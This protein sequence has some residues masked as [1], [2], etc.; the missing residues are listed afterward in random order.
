MISY[1]NGIIELCSPN[2][3]SYVNS[4]YKTS[5]ITTYLGN[6]ADFT[7][8]RCVRETVGV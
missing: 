1:I 4:N 6:R 5:K 3:T 8:L 7:D 2:L